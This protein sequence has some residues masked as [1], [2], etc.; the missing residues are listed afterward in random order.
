MKAII[1]GCGYVGS[2]VARLWHHQGLGVT[3]TTT[4]PVRIS[5]LEAIADSVIQLQGNDAEGFKTAC[6]AR[7]S[8]FSVL[9]LRPEPPRDIG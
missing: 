9:A 2:A 5:V 8:S 7:I 4:T 1:V 3:A 6:R